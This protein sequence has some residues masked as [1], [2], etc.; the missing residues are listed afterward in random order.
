MTTMEAMRTDDT[1]RYER[2]PLRTAAVVL[3]LVAVTFGQRLGVPF[4]TTQLPLA[5]P[6]GL[7]A[8]GLLF[9]DGSARLSSTRLVFYML[10]IGTAMFSMMWEKY[11]ISIPSFLYFAGLYFILTVMVPT[12]EREYLRYINIFNNL[13]L[14]F[15]AIGI[16]QMIGQFTGAP[17]WSL[18]D[19]VP[20]QILLEGYNT[21]PVLEYG[22]DFHKSTGDFFLEP[23]YL[24]QFCGIALVMEYLY[25][26]KWWRAGIYLVAIYSSF[27]GTGMLFLALF[28]VIEAIRAG[29]LYLLIVAALV[30][31]VALTVVP[32]ADYLLGRL[33]EI[34]SELSSSYA[35]FVGPWVALSYILNDFSG[36]MLGR[37]PGY[38]ERIFD[39]SPF[40]TFP[41]ITKMI[42][43][44]GFVCFVCFMGF[45]GYCFFDRTRHWP[46]ALCMLFLYLFLTAALLQPHVVLLIYVICMMMPR[47]TPE[48]ERLALRPA[49][50]AL[51]PA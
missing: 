44:Y 23:S 22:S 7:L 46:F 1:P 28:F 42:M 16:Y 30:G 29:R 8:V 24:S 25:F 34:E 27:A 12:S 18:F 41:V 47:S 15:A 14:V 13:M 17:K 21:R 4:G 5:L 50:L 26:R 37:G 31:A 9:L 39:V 33:F 20:K 2:M 49:S 35:R 19:H 40:F 51:R 48:E 32:N 36:F 11:F 45:I 38:L 3:I 10:A 6:I 43:E